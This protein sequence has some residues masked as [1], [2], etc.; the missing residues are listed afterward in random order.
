MKPKPAKHSNP[1]PTTPP[2]P[3]PIRGKRK[4]QPLTEDEKN[5]LA[6]KLIVAHLENRDPHALS[7]LKT[8]FPRDNWDRLIADFIAWEQTQSSFA[9]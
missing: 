3:K 4:K 5:A 8:I 2:Q 7:F 9:E 1:F 6:A